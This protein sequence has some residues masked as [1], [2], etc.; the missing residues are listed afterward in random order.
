MLA[1]YSFPIILICLYWVFYLWISKN[2]S[3]ELKALK[4]GENIPL[5]DITL[6]IPFRNE[7]NAIKGIIESIH[8]QEHYPFA[9]IFIDD[10]SSD[11][12]VQMLKNELNDLA[13]NCSLLHLTDDFGKKAAID[14]GVRHAD[15]NY[16]L[17]L[18][19]DVLMK[20]NYF[21][22]LQQ[23][24]VKDL[25]VLPVLLTGAKGLM[26]VFEWDYLFI[27]AFSYRLRY[28]K[29]LTASGANL[30]FK[31]KSYLQLIKNTKG[32]N[33]LSGDDYFLLKEMQKAKMDIGVSGSPDLIVT[34]ELPPTLSST[35]Q[36]RLRW[37]G[38]IS[39]LEFLALLLFSIAQL[40]M[41]LLLFTTSFYG[42][43]LFM[44]K[45]W[46]DILLVKEYVHSLKLKNREYEIIP[47]FLCFP[48]YMI[49]L[50]LTNLFVKK[51]WKGRA[52]KKK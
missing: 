2:D 15:T 30:L 41:C 8:D 34:T 32:K 13:I 24:K 25:W 10:H 48:F 20:P 11:G 1:L 51:E 31:K 4:G 52:L 47:F 23:L 36:Q 14:L 29:V 5:D 7:A 42:L 26:K 38:K 9:V 22:E 33:Y 37:L 43:I 12:S 19:A 35:L 40:V 44:F 21:Q 3:E 28:R 27:N 18:D 45:T 46:I 39:I 17:Q 16:I 50:F 6:I 49:G